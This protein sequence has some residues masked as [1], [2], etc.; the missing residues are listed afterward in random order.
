MFTG[1]LPGVILSIQ[2]T[3]SLV[4]MSNGFRTLTQGILTDS[5]GTQPPH[6]SLLTL[7][8]CSFLLAY[9]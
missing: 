1:L 6:C 3:C 4:Y 9:C 5:T 8:Q 2:P 7:T